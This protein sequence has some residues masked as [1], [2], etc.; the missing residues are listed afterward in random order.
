[1]LSGVCAGPLSFAL[2]SLRGNIWRSSM[3]GGLVHTEWYK[4]ALRPSNIG[5][6]RGFSNYYLRRCGDDS[7]VF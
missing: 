4:N 5:G 6:H 7:L 2:A 3:A 1:M